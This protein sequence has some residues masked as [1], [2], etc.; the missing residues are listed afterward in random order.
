MSHCWPKVRISAERT[1]S[2]W[3][4]RGVP[5]PCPLQ[6]NEIGCGAEDTGLPFQNRSCS[7]S[8]EALDRT[9]ASRSGV[10]RKLAEG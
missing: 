5:H 8:G 7:L 4:K 2:S 9:P 3:S 1:F 10:A 6:F